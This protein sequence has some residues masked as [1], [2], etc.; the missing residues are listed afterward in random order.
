MEEVER[1]NKNGVLFNHTTLLR[2]HGGLFKAGDSYLHCKDMDNFVS[3][4][5]ADD[6]REILL[7]YKDSKEEVEELRLC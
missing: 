3:W 1:Y 5:E 4:Y 6:V 2:F 7:S